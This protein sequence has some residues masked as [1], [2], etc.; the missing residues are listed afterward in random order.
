MEP[1]PL[2]ARPAPGLGGQAAIHVC[3]GALVRLQVRS[4]GGPLAVLPGQGFY[5]PAASISK[6]LDCLLRLRCNELM[7]GFHLHPKPNTTLKL[8]LNAI[9][10]LP[11]MYLQKPSPV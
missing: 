11:L 1:P 9:A 4:R 8:A 2:I 6:M 7:A 3:Y 10:C 5:V